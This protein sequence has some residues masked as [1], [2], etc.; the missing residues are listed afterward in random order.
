MSIAPPPLPT[1]T[2]ETGTSET[3]AP[4]RSDAPLVEITGVTR[5]YDTGTPALRGIDLRV[6]RGEFVAILGPSGSGKS[7]LLNLMAGLDRP[8]AGTVTVDG[9]RVS[10]LREAR[11]A[12]FRRDHIGMVF[13]FFHLLDDLSALDNVMLPA[14]LGSTAKADAAARARNLVAQLGIESRASDYPGRLSGGE[15]QRVA[16]ARALINRPALLLAD[17]P[18]GALDSA[19]AQRVADLL[20]AINAAGQTVVMVSHDRDLSARVATRTVSLVDGRIVADTR[21][22]SRRMP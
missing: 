13:Q 1:G 16:I 12:R 22:A 18:T 10:A 21:P 3:G 8:T 7:T 4:G 17:E 15:R 20:R 5:H 9:V 19:S 11:S 2:S 14:L 6:H